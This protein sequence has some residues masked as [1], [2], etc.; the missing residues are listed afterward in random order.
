MTRS[1]AIRKMQSLISKGVTAEQQLA[2]DVPAKPAAKAKPEP[3]VKEPKAPKAKRE[4]KTDE[5]PADHY[6]RDLIIRLFVRDNLSPGEIVKSA[7][8]YVGLRLADKGTSVSNPYVSRVLFGSQNSGGVSAEQ[9][10]R[11]KLRDDR[12]KEAKKTEAK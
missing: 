12:D 3:K 5:K 9:K 10:E 6:D 1:N 8:K 2:G 7:D 11:R 4:P